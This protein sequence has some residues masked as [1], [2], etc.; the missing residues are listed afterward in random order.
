MTTAM[1]M[2]AMASPPSPG[3]SGR[4]AFSE[5]RSCSSR[6]LFFSLFLFL[7]SV[8]TE[9]EGRGVSVVTIDVRVSMVAG[10]GGVV[11][12]GEASG[13]L[14]VLVLKNKIEA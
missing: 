6:R 12:V 14:V 4:L 7:A 5:A 3:G 13:V 8:L 10:G 1:T 2:L 9:V 11:V